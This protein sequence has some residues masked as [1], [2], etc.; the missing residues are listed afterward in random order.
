MEWIEIMERI[1]ILSGQRPEGAE[2][3][4]VFAEG[5]GRGALAVSQLQRQRRAA[6]RATGTAA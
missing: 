3:L 5:E 2:F 4:S 1:E 6:L